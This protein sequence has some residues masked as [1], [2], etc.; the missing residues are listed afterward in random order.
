MS[1]VDERSKVMHAMKTREQ[2]KLPK[3]KARD[4][5]NLPAA[6]YASKTPA[7]PYIVTTKDRASIF[8]QLF[9]QRMMN[10]EKRTTA[11]HQTYNVWKDLTSC[12]HNATFMTQL[13]RKTIGRN[14]V[15]HNAQIHQVF[16]MSKAIKLKHSTA[17]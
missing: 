11:F 5:T 2:Q 15:V 12:R 14:N 6:G 13:I 10:E 16:T 9:L 4:I 7:M 3:K 1:S 17:K 8:D